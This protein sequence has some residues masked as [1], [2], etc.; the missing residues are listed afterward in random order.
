MNVWDA[1]AARRAVRLERYRLRIEDDERGSM[2]F[3]YEMRG[4]LSAECQKRES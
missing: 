1:E 4:N 2:H 3:M